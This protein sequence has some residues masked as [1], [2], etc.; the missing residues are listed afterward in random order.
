MTGNSSPHEKAPCGTAP[1]TLA[2]M[3]LHI[4][5]QGRGL[6]ALNASLSRANPV[7][8]DPWAG[9][10]RPDKCSGHGDQFS[11]TAKRLYRPSHPPFSQLEPSLPLCP[12]SFSAPF[13]HHDNNLFSAPMPARPPPPPVTRAGS[14]SHCAPAL[15]ALVPV[16]PFLPRLPPLLPLPGT[17][18]AFPGF[19]PVKSSP[20]LW[21]P[22]RG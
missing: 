8:K 19:F 10:M 3:C 20:P 21:T 5:P 11:D 2:G 4:S 1:L 22:L 17:R 18:P 16:A 9:P 6:R 12:H 13:I 14:R 15:K 7:G